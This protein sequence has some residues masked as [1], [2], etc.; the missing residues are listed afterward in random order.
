MNNHHPESCGA[1]AGI[2]GAPNRRGGARLARLAGM[3]A[4]LVI[5]PGLRAGI[6]EPEAVFYGRIINRASGQVY[7]LSAGTLT[8]RLNSP[9]GPAITLSTALQPLKGGAYSYRLNVPHEA[10]GLGLSVSPGVVPLAAQPAACSHLEIRVDGVPARILAPGGAT[11]E[12]S[13]PARAATYRL[14]LEVATPLA[15]SDGNGLPDWWENQ[16]LTDDPLADPD[17][18]GRNNRAEFL[19]G[20]DPNHDDRLPSLA[21]RELRAYA[22]GTTLVTLR[23]RDADSAAADLTYTLTRA[24]QRGTVYLRHAQAD[25]ENS[26]SALTA[27]ATFSQADVNAGRLVF[28]HQDADGIAGASFQLT[29]RDENPSHPAATSEVA[30]TFYQPGNRISAADL[31]QIAA[32]LPLY[33]P[34]IAGLLADEQ[35]M[36]VNYLLSH[37]LG[38]VIGDASTEALNQDLCA[39][40]AAFSLAQYAAQY[41]PKYGRDRSHVLA[42]G[43][44]QDRL[45]GGMEADVLIGGRGDDSLHGNGGADLYLFNSEEDGNDTFEDFNPDEGDVIDLSRVFTGIPTQLTNY[46]QL[47]AAGTN[48]QLRINFQGAG[49]SYTDMV[50]TLAGRAFASLYDLVE[51][52]GLVTGDKVLP[53]RISIVATVP[54]ASEN[55][56]PAGEFTLARSGAALAA[57]T[58]NVQIT[59]SAANGIDYAFVP[60]Q[61][62][63][64][65]GERSVTVQILPYA[66]T[67]TELAEVVALTVL[68]GDNYVAAAPASAQVTI[69]D[70]APQLA[71][72]ALE[73][74][75]IK[76]GPVSGV[77]V[78]SRGGVLDRSVLVR[79]NISGTA[80]KGI[81]YE[82]I[83]TYVNLAA[84]QATALLFVEPKPSAVISNSAEYVEVSLQPDASYK[85]GKPAAARVVLVEEQLTLA[86]WRNR[87][88]A[89]ASG[90][91][92]A[93]AR[94]D[95]DQTGIQN[96]QRYAFGL[97]TKSPQVSPG[98]P[99]FAVRDGRLTVTFRRPASVTDVQYAVEVSDDLV[100]WHAGAGYVE[101]FTPPEYANEPEM[102]GYRIQRTLDETRTMFMRVRV[103]YTPENP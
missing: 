66:D 44:G 51:S 87:F 50:V 65:P 35:Q 103:S 70:L 96:L 69:E 100:S 85:L 4:L 21:T 102:A 28:A 82:N 8:W 74:V 11:F 78:I 67:L 15:D 75:A 45:V 90:S 16:F 84:Q 76:A 19:A 68:P 60:A 58:V 61:V 88:F 73:P 18:D 40:S 101:P 59:G 62:K 13:Q 7:L 30:V 63:F 33:A 31:A 9:N 24:P 89:D 91:L 36:V 80:A 54:A 26:D 39:P 20:S 10:L 2:V 46:L 27:G 71:I 41:V 43:T 1:P 29:L 93:F 57:L 32:G 6:A 3:C 95:P 92:L 34:R 38:Y 97:H 55:G 86:E 79:L 42:G 56:P 47:T 25:P 72:E 83:P 23:A 98:G 49:A 99:L 52:G 64:P 12:V 48:S 77:F 94:E 17:G 37:D 5:C 53:S 22:G 14:D 81:D